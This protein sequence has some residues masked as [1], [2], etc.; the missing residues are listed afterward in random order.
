MNGA[1]HFSYG[2]WP[3]IIRDTAQRALQKLLVTFGAK[4]VPKAPIH[5]ILHLIRRALFRLGE[6][7]AHLRLVVFFQVLA[8]EFEPA[9]GGEGL[10]L[11]DVVVGAVAGEVRSFL[12]STD[13]AT[14]LQRALTALSFEVKMEIR[15]VPNKAGE[16]EPKVKA[17]AVPR[18]RRREGASRDDDD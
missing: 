17:R 10:D 2:L 3:G 6:D 13:L 7:L 12:D 8:G 1:E 16:L 9:G 11:H 4:I 15:F 14:E 18:A 5:L